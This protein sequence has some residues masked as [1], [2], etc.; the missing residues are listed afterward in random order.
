MSS[1]ITNIISESKVDHQETGYIFIL[2][3]PKAEKYFKINYSSNLGVINDVVAKYNFN[4]SSNY[5]LEYSR[6]VLQPKYAESLI[7][8][9]LA[10]YHVKHA[11][12]DLYLFEDLDIAIDNVNHIVDTSNYLFEFSNPDSS[13]DDFT[14]VKDN[15]SEETSVISR[16]APLLF[17][18]LD[19][20]IDIAFDYILNQ[21]VPI[22]PDYG[23][24][25]LL[26]FILSVQK[27]STHALKA[28]QA[29]FK[30]AQVFESSEITPRNKEDVLFCYKKS[31]E[32]GNKEAT[33]KLLHLYYDGSEKYNVEQNYL[34]AIKYLSMLSS[35]Y[36][37]R[38]SL[39]YIYCNGR[40]FLLKQ[41][42]QT[43]LSLCS[44]DSSVG[45]FW[46]LDVIKAKVLIN[47]PT[48]DLGVARQLDW[49]E[50][51]DVL[52]IEE[53]SNKHPY[54]LLLNINNNYSDNSVIKCKA[55]IEARYLLA[56]YLLGDIQGSYCEKIK[57]T[58]DYFLKKIP[59]DVDNAITYL[60]E[61]AIAGH[62]LACIRLADLLETSD[63]VS[64]NEKEAVRFRNRAHDCQYNIDSRLSFPIFG[65]S[66]F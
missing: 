11:H 56:L 23:V 62:P 36:P 45:T 46:D 41:N 13:F 44:Y 58:N 9:R 10:K 38:V 17:H 24:Q 42:I 29:A 16:K 57:N 37:E 49:E 14:M 8:R 25:T 33:K 21:T 30:L 31:S 32:L 15:S 26:K 59:I 65:L 28:A 19:N 3:D 27:E 43:G 52:I 6:V 4:K 20:K 55:F 40:Q 2:S 66:L 60:T 18:S 48:P 39:A 54:Q 22:D 47:K 12:N 53:Y 5:E 35:E 63:V 64:K 50:E 51:E 1:K 34:Q 7:Q 61:A